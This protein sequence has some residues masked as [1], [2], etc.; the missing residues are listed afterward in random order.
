[1]KKNLFPVLA[2]LL[3]ACSGAPDN[4]SEHSTQANASE[5]AYE[6]TVSTLNGR[7]EKELFWGPPGYGEDTLTDEREIVYVLVLPKSIR[8]K[9]PAKDLSDGYN[10]AIAGIDRIQLLTQKP[11]EKYLD[12]SVTVSG[13]LF[14]AQTGHHH[15]EVLM[16]VQSVK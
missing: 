7:L 14:G 4:R 10:A 13:T 8:M 6:P 16:D 5:Y 12:Q 9:A 1:M 3:A 11:M 15:T 2:V